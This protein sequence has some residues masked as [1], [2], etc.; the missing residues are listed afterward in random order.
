MQKAKDRYHNYRKKIRATISNIND[1]V[2]R[3][4][5][6]LLSFFYK[7]NSHAQQSTKSTKKHQSKKK[8]KTQKSTKSTKTQNANEGIITKNVPK[9]HLRGKK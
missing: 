5:L 3:V 6:N 2:I 1:E 7:K 9:K 4:I 8:K